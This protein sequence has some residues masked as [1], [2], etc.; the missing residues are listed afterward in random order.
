MDFKIQHEDNKKG[1]VHYLDVLNNKVNAKLKGLDQL[2]K[3]IELQKDAHEVDQNKHHETSLKLSNDAIVALSVKI[4]RERSN[5]AKLDN[6]LKILSA[7][8]KENVQFISKLSNQVKQWEDKYT[9][10]DA[11]YTKEVG[12]LKANIATKEQIINDIQQT[13]NEHLSA[14]EVLNE[15]KRVSN[16]P[17][18][19]GKF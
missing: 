5:S 17:T 1:T 8:A 18:R 6:E 7:R 15:Q 4:E 12:D 9:D 2:V 3:E 19:V 13:L 14:S 16:I 11:N 10:L